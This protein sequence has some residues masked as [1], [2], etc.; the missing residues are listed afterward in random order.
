MVMNFLRSSLRLKQALIVAPSR[1]GMFPKE[2]YRGLDVM[3]WRLCSCLEKA[4]YVARH[5]VGQAS[6][7][8]KK[9]M[10]INDDLRIIA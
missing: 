1:L 8:M 9:T 6:P 7:K 2:W 10:T 4:K 3:L 5:F